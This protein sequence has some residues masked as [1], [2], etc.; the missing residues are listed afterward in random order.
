MGESSFY[1]GEHEEALR[2]FDAIITAKP[3]KPSYLLPWSHLRRGTIYNLSG[4]K[5]EAATEYRQVLALDDTLHV[6]DLARAF[7]KNQKTN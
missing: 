6:H 4:K 2:Q 7:L 1:L 5:A 3:T